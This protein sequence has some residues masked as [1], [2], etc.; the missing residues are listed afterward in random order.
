MRVAR[1]WNTDKQVVLAENLRMA[2]TFFSRLKGLLG[3]SCLP[4]GQGLAIR[5]CNSV[6]MFG[7]CYPIDVLFVNAAGEV[8]RV[9]HCLQ[10]WR[11][12]YYRIADWVV[13]L[14]AGT[15]AATNTE[16]GDRIEI[17]S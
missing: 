16:R 1:L 7:M 5:P 6:H 9:S 17:I 10:P 8:L 3:T 14:P 15:A 4:A 11:A 2:D 12:A 13:E